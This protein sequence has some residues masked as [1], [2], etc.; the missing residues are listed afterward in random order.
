MRCIFPNVIQAINRNSKLKYFDIFSRTIELNSN[1]FQP[2]ISN[3]TVNDMAGD[4]DDEMGEKNNTIQAI[5]ARPLS[6][7]LYFYI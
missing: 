6:T 5:V 2:N 1:S 4:D 7:E 3:G